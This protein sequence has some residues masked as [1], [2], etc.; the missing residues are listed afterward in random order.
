MGG[1]SGGH[2][3]PSLAVAHELKNRHKSAKIYYV[4]ESG[5]RFVSLVQDSADVDKVVRIRV[6]K[7]RRYNNQSFIKKLVDVPTNLRNLRDITFTLFG[8][9]QSVFKLT[10]IRPNVAFIKG[11]FVGVPMGIACAMFRI[12]FVTHDSDT[13]PGLANRII[14]RWARYNAVGMPIEFYNYPRSKIFYSGIPLSDVYRFVDTKL[15]NQYR[16]DLNIPKQARVITVT[17]GSLGALRLNKSFVKIA[18]ELLAKDQN[19]WVIH[20]TGSKD[21]YYNDFPANLK[22]RVIETDFSNYL[23]QLTG[24]AD[25]VLARAGATSIAEL[26]LQGKAVI[27]VPNPEL[28]GGHQIKNADHLKSIAAVKVLTESELADTS[29]V[30]DALKELLN[31]DDEISRLAKSLHKL[32]TPDASSKIVEAILKAK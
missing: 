13:V 15:K 29:Y 19:L 3:T 17:G 26:A 22:S 9:L 8:I 21:S 2:I 11:G 7:Y 27:L 30:T 31:K 1:G 4:I 25:I 24:A 16:L 32:A 14:S 20:Q 28:T 10:L 23:Y 6:G 5:S 12:P 18:K